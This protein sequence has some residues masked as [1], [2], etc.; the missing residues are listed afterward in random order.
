MNP[1]AQFLETICCQCGRPLVLRLGIDADAESAAILA[2]A[3][4]CERCRLA[5]MATVPLVESSRTCG[6]RRP[7]RLPGRCLNGSPQISGGTA[8]NSRSALDIDAA[9]ASAV[10]PSLSAS[11]FASMLP[12]GHVDGIVP[13]AGARTCHYSRRSPR[14][15]TQAP[16]ASA[17]YLCREGADHHP[18]PVHSSKARQDPRRTPRAARYALNRHTVRLQAVEAAR[19]RGVSPILEKKSI[20]PPAKQVFVHLCVFS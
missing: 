10:P 13:H 18:D 3:V 15:D 12:A 6:P 4:I 2:P 20:W 16:S 14:L 9:E 5:R 8:L 11:S 19:G 1:N 7:S 17:H